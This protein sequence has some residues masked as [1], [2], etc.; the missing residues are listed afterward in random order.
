MYN[1]QKIDMIQ[2]K[3]NSKTAKLNPIISLLTLNV[4]GLS[5]PSR[6]CQLDKI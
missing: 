1:K 5:T 3:T 2:I 6:D 4:S